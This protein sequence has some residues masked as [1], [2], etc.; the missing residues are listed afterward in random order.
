MVTLFRSTMCQQE[1]A[2]PWSIRERCV[3]RAGDRWCQCAG[4]LARLETGEAAEISL[5]R[6]K[7]GCQGCGNSIN[8]RWEIGADLVGSVGSGGRC[9]DSRWTGVD[10]KIC[11]R[12]EAIETCYRLTTIREFALSKLL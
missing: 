6:R 7:K 9:R 8:A 11:M 12:L 4:A 3:C 2:T 5:L 10:D 1:A